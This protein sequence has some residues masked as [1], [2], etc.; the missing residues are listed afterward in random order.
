[1]HEGPSLYMALLQKSSQSVHPAPHWVPSILW[2]TQGD[3]L[4]WPG[5]PGGPGGPGGPWAPSL[6]L[7]PGKDTP[8]SPFS[9]FCPLSPG[10][11]GAPCWPGEG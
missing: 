11:P 10:E 4:V 6:P 3:L 1:M 8:G 5:C 2:D 7:G 9:P